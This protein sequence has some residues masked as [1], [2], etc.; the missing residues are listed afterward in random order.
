MII[1]LV[2]ALESVRAFVTSRDICFQNKA[3][4]QVLESR[5]RLRFLSVTQRDVG[6]AAEAP[7][8]RGSA[9]SRVRGR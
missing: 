3:V 8:M 9:S 5:Q 4:G 1:Q 6:Q 7:L 2:F